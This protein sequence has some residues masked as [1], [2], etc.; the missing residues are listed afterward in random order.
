MQRH[1]VCV[2]QAEQF[3]RRSSFLGGCTANHS[4]QAAAAQAANVEHPIRFIN[5][6]AN[7]GYEIANF[8]QNWAPERNVTRRQWKN[9]ILQYAA[10]QR[11]GYLRW[12]AAGA[13]KDGYQ[14]K[15]S[16]QEALSKARRARRSG[17]T[18]EVHAFEL[19][20]STAQLLHWLVNA[21]GV[22]DLVTVHNQPVANVSKL[23]P[24]P[25]AIAAGGERFGICLGR[26]CRRRGHVDVLATSLDDFITQ[27]ALSRVYHVTIDAEGWDA[28]ILEGLRSSLRAKIV[29][30]VEFEY[31]VKGFWGLPH[32]S[33]DRRSLAGTLRWMSDMGWFCFMQARSG[34]LPVS[35]PCWRDS[36]EVNRWIN[37]VCAQRGS[38]M[39]RVLRDFTVPA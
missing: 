23:V 31:H 9:R 6:G 3:V 8:L 32:S 39:F 1:P 17:T 33:P 18:V 16:E 38:E 27:N 21:T 19:S 2:E 12:A 24:V 7:K 14:S 13:C 10:V 25:P 4:W 15:R 11:S 28:V 36:F 22:G 5:V 34:L 29:Q 30:L 37:L 26:S 35:P 20:A